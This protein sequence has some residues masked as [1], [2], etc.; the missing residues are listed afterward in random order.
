M[1][2]CRSRPD[3]P[4]TG[5]P[6]RELIVGAV[7]GPKPK[8]RP[9]KPA[10]SIDRF[11]SRLRCPSGRHH[12]VID[13]DVGAAGSSAVA[14]AVEMDYTAHTKTKRTS[15][16]TLTSALHQVGSTNE[17]ARHTLLASRSR[18]ADMNLATSGR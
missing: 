13:D 1:Q 15:D 14:G 6:T 10:N 18:G 17:H 4:K 5:T 9:P 7:K 12:R 16:Q 3:K 2:R 11:A 8:T